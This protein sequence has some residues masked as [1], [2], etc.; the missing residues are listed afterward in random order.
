MGSRTECYI[1]GTPLV[2]TLDGLTALACPLCADTIVPLQ[3]RTLERARA[4]LDEWRMRNNQ[5]GG[6][7]VYRED[8]QPSENDDK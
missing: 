2:V 5:W 4:S 8:L 7:T 3:Q 6:E 1:C